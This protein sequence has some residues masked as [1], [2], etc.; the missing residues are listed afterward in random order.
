MYRQGST[1]LPEG[2]RPLHPRPDAEHFWEEAI[3]Y[4]TKITKGFTELKPS[5]YTVGANDSVLDYR[6]PP[7]DKSNMSRYLFG[8]FQHCLY[9][10]E[11]F[12]SDSDGRLA[13]ILDREN[14]KWFKPRKASSSSSTSGEQTTLSTN[15][16]SW[17]KQRL[18]GYCS[19][20]S[21]RWFQSQRHD[22]QGVLR[23]GHRFIRVFR[24]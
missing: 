4:E 21:L 24:R 3:G 9:S 17:P 6:N 7:A 11:K 22:G 8:G 1:L 5:A 2:D 19:H 23:S 14:V 16:T 10:V 20:N 12:Q 13:V 18:Q 15:P